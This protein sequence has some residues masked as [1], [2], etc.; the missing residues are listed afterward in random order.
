MLELFLAVALWVGQF[1]ETKFEVWLTP[2]SGGPAKKYS[3]AASREVA[4]KVAAALKTVGTTEV[5]PVTSI[6]TGT[7]TTPGGPSAGNP[8]A[9]GGTA[10]TGSFS[11][12]DMEALIRTDPPA[13]KATDKRIPYGTLIDVLEE[14]TVGGKDYVKVQKQGD[15]NTV[16]GWTAKSNLG[17][18]KEFDPTM[19]PADLV[20]VSK[21]KG[22]ELT[23]ASIY[24]TRGKYLSDQAKALGVPVEALAAVLKVESGGRAFSNDGR[25][26]IRFENHQF[27]KYWGKTHQADYDQ[28]FKHSA[29]ESWKGHQWR[30]DATG[31]WIDSHK[32]QDGEWEQMAYAR[33]LDDTAALQSASYGAGQ[34]MGFNYASLGFASV[35]DMVKAFDAGIK[36][37]L[38]GM[39][40]FIKNNKACMDALKAG[41]YTAFATSYNGPG[42]AA[43]Y[44]ALIKAA[45]DAY[46]KVTAGKS[47]PLP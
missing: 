23:M 41:D 43:T 7:G 6:R 4:D 28:H 18:V 9:G 37:Q 11:I 14:K 2:K 12:T 10:A 20:D 42:Q 35:Q 16:Y 44:G 24:N 30:K 46:K 22:D 31:A 25:T 5:K 17:S 34:V 15:P 21:L 27:Y 13:L 33:S 32:N 38:D 8:A 3:D 29:T 19:A 36:G 1:I 39:I 26:I 45:A 47:T 40:A